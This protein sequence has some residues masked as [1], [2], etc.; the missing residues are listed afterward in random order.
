MYFINES[1]RKNYEH[2]VNMVFRANTDPEYKVLSYI[3]AL[4]DIYARCINDPVFHDFP[5]AWKYEYTDTSYTSHD[6]LGEFLVVDFEVNKDQNQQPI[7]SKNYKSLSSGYKKLLYLVDNLFN[8]SNNDFN[9]MDALGTWDD[10]SIKVYYQALSIRLENI[11]IDG[12]N[13][14]IN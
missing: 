13:V 8:S 2:L 6:E 4:P 10:Q 5:H 9:L 14:I 3:L 1:H 11:K 7:Y 12:L